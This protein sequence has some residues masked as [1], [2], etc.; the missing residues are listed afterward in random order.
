MH[1]L[2]VTYSARVGRK[3]SSKAI[4]CSVLPGGICVYI[5]VTYSVRVGRKISSTAVVCS[6]LP[7]GI[8][9]YILARAPCSRLVGDIGLAFWMFH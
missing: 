1:T 7:G 6:V 4:V 5:L 8:C 2:L 9:V 3:I